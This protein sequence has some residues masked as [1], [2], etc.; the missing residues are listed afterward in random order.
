MN[1]KFLFYSGFFLL[2]MGGFYF[3]LTRL[4]PG[5][6]Q[7]KL[8]VLATVQPFRFINQHGEVVTDQDLSGRVYVVE[9]FFTTCPNIC[10]MMNQHMKQVY[11]RFQNDDRIRILSF[12]CNPKTDSVP[13]LR[14]YADSLGV[15]TRHWYFLTGSKDSLYQL[16]RNSF[17]IDDPK[18]NVL[19]IDEQFMHTQF[20]ALVDRSG[21]VRKIYDGLKQKE[22]DDLIEAIP[23]LLQETVT[24]KRFSTN[25]FR[26]GN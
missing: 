21:R 1:K 18:N 25:L 7:V 23:Q 19:P 15:D 3:A 4:I 8:P 10:P 17:L 13:L 2:L 11:D 6:G 22:I 24:D 12:T 26:V 20:F 9:Y 14:R 5:F 16:A